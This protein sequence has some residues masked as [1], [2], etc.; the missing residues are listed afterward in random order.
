MQGKIYEI[1]SDHA[2]PPQK[3][4]GEMTNVQK[5]EYWKIHCRN[6]K[7]R[8]NKQKKSGDKKRNKP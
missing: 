7:A 2:R 4:I 3:R 8:H 5:S 1:H 6:S